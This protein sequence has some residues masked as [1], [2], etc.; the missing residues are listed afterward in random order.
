MFGWL[1]NF[2][3]CK[4]NLQLTNYNCLVPLQ[5]VWVLQ[6][7]FSFATRVLPGLRISSR[8]FQAFEKSLQKEKR[9]VLFPFSQSAL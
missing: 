4:K 2:A 5:K 8:C 9:L 1:Q 3:K 6:Q 7:V